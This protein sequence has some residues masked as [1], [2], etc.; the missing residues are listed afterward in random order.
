MHSILN[1]LPCIKVLSS[2]ETIAL[3][4]D[5]IKACDEPTVSSLGAPWIKKY[6]HFVYVRPGVVK[7]SYIK[8]D[9]DYKEE[10]MKQLD[11]EFGMIL[12]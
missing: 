5:Q 6:H 1:I 10:T 12:R 7:C 9:A 4:Y 3:T 8:G 11:G 2:T